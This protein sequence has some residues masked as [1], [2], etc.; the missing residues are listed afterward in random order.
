MLKIIFNAGLILLPVFFLSVKHATNIILFSLAITSLVFINKIFQDKLYVKFTRKNYWIA[1]LI[2]VFPILAIAISQTLRQEFYPNNWDAPLRFFLCLPIFFAISQG[3]LSGKN[4]R[5]ISEIWLCWSMPIGIF[6][7]LIS[8]VYYPAKNWGAYLTTYFVDPLT[9]CSYALL[10]SLLSI[11]GLIYFNK[12]MSRFNIL[13]SLISIVVGFYLSISSGAR[14]GWLGFPII[15]IIFWHTFKTEF[16]I[17]KANVLILIL[18]MIMGVLIYYNPNFLNKLHLAFQQFSSYKLNEINV[19]TSFEMRI[20]FYRMGIQYF[21]ERPWYGWGDL[22]WLYSMNRGEFIQYAS[23]F[24]RESP[25]HGFHNEI[26]TSS[27]RSGIWGL[28]SSA[29]LFAGVTYLAVRGMC[30]KISVEHSAISFALLVVIVHL[31]FTGFTTEITNLTFLSAFIGSVISVLL[32][33]KI[34]LE[35]NNNIEKI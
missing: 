34:F 31:F 10:F 35:E 7:M 24:T 26:I 1:I 6:V 11:S 23:E 12:K 29:S 16:N 4:S 14:T 32:G 13:F 20:S 18:L 21:I 22:S 33:E 19:D 27:V 25:K 8:R 17:K 30:M 5:T 15:I 2:F 9:F 3:C 28:M